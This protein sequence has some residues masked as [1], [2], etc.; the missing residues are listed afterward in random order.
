MKVINMFAAVALLVF[1]AA[2]AAAPSAQEQAQRQMQ[3][4]FN[5]APV[6]GEVRSGEAQSTTMRGIE[7]GVLI[8]PGGQTWRE[9]RNGP[10]VLYGG[11]L[12]CVVLAAIV[13]YYARRGTLR[14]KEP[15]TGRKLVRFDM[16]DRV[17]HWVAA[18][19]F[20]LLGIT[21]LTL[22]F[23]KHL[24]LPLLGY[25]AF[26]WL[27]AIGKNI[28]NFT[29]PIFLLS[30]VVMFAAYVK[31]NF[32]Q[33]A[34][35]EWI[36]H[37]GG[38]V[39]GEHVPSHRFNFGEKVWFWLGVSGLGLVVSLSG[40]VLDFQNFEQGRFVMQAA[41][42][43][44]VVGAVLFLAMSFGHI[45]MGTVGVAGAYEAMRDGTVDES[46]AKEHHELW[47]RE[48]RAAGAGAQGAPQD[49]KPR[50]V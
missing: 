37:A 16:V 26:S 41:N 2:A 36:A 34:D 32:W 28:H 5:N 15:E 44:H 13:V 8:Q 6:W 4:P 24:L 20:C 18:V 39:R 48:A 3:Q 46:W 40:F 42:V 11:I 7:T 43:V 25:E 33:A 14:L 1:A 45:Y 27:A 21:G 9:L 10:I 19:S 38:L 49:A 17:T 47:V 50:A 35:A 23:G 31:D 29:G 22:L 30:I 12:L